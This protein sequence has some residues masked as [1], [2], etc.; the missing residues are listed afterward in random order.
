MA[1]IGVEI[2]QKLIAVLDRKSHGGECGRAQSQFAGPMDDVDARV[3]GFQFIGQLSGPVRRV[4][5]DDQDLGARSVVVDSG[6]QARQ[7]VPFVVRCQ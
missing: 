6:N 7:I 1:A 5:V 4:I 3:G 2:E